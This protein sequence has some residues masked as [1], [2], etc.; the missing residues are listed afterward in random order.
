MQLML[1]H[2]MDQTGDIYHHTMGGVS[3]FR[4]KCH[5]FSG[6]QMA[7]PHHHNYIIAD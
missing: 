5:F 7:K 1:F 4:L 6:C 3:I 2:S